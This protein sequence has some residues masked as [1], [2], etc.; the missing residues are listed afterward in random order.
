MQFC[1]VAL[2]L[3]LEQTFTYLVNGHSPVVG[4]RVLVPFRTGRL[5]GIVTALHD[6]QPSFEAKNLHSVIDAA[7]VLD[8][9]LLKLGEWI[10][11]YYMA[12][13]GEVL[14]TMLPLGAEVRRAWAWRITE[15]GMEA[16]GKSA[17]VGASRRS[18]LDVDDQMLE[19]QVLD[20]LAAGD[21]AL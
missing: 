8:E 16:L 4:G 12:P 20:Y 18:K 7:P 19:Y 6:Q 17:E 15:A 3:P 2:P 9:H 5:P 11:G 14:R 10:V 13:I 1:D 21:D